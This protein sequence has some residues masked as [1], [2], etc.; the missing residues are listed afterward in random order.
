MCLNFKAC[1]HNHLQKNLRLFENSFQVSI[2]LYDDFG[3]FAVMV[4]SE[5]VVVGE[6]KFFTKK[7]RKPEKN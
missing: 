2:F 7:I 1:I 4:F 6:M 5:R 3:I